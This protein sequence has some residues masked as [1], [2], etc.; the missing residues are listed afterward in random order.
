MFDMSRTEAIHREWR[1]G[2]SAAHRQLAEVGQPTTVV[3]EL[4][5]SY[6]TTSEVSEE[7]IVRRLAEERLIRVPPANQQR[8]DFKRIDVGGKPMSEMI[9]EERR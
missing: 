7:E 3:P 6:E 4:N 5:D 1:T 9:I 2:T 8:S